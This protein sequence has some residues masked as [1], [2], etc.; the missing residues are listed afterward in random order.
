MQ[1]FTAPFI[2]RLKLNQFRT[3]FTGKPVW[4]G[5][6]LFA[7]MPMLPAHAQVRTIWQIGRFDESPVEF[8]GHA[9][10]SVAFRVGSS[11][12]LK[13]WPASQETGSTYRIL[14]PLGS[15]GGSY[16]L[17]IAALIDQPR[18][19]ALQIGIN[20]HSG[21]YFLHP[22]LSYSRS[23]FTYAFDPHESQST[24][25]IDIPAA[26]LKI[27]EN[28][29]SIT[30]VNDPPTNA[31]QKE[32]GGLSYDALELREEQAGR[33]KSVSELSASL[34]PTIFYRQSGT[35]LMEI[36]D[37][38]IRFPGSWKAGSADLEISGKHYIARL[39]GGEFGEERVSFEVPEWTGRVEAALRVAGGSSP[40]IKASLVAQRKWTIFVVPHT[41]LDVGFTD[42]QG[43]VA[44]TQ[45]RVLTQAASLIH[46]F[47]DF[48][49]S[50]DGS[51]NLEQF[52]DTRPESKQKELLDLIRS[53]KMAMPVQY[54]NLL[55]GYASLETLYQSLYESKRLSVR[56]GL[57]F[58]YANITDVP[59]Y[60]GSYPSVLAASGV[61]YWVAA[62]NNDRAPVF[63][64]DH[65]NE[66]SPFWW[67]GPDGNK[68]LFWYSRHYMQVQTLFGLPPQLEAVRES[69]PIYLQAY[70]SPAYK[71]DV[72]LIFGTQVENTDLFPSTATFAGGWN[73]GYAFPKL[74]YATFPDFFHY[75]EMHNAKDLPTVK[76]DGGG[77]WED[78][79]GSDAYFAAQ[80]RQNQNRVLS[81]EVL[82]SV[83]H[84][85]DPNL[86]P[87]SDAFASIWRN[88][89]LFAEHTWLS[90]NSVSQPDHE[91]SV[92]QLRVKDG[93]A[94]TAS[95]QIEDVMNR[96]LSQLADQ[97]HIPENTLVIF[98]S[99][100]WQRDAIV[101]TDLFEHPKLVDLAT[102]KEVPLQ[103]LYQKQ[104]FLHV[105][106]LAKDLPSVGYK[107]FSIS[108][109]ENGG[110][111]SARTNESVVENSF[112]RVTVD[113]DS[114]AVK[115]IF[116][117]QLRREIVDSA[118][119]YKFGQY[120]YVTG[121]DG[122]TQLVNPFPAL[123][124]GQLTVH[125]AS[126]GRL[127]GV[128]HLP[129]GESIRL[130]SSDVNTPSIETEILLFTDQ[131]KIEFRLRIHKDYTNAKE[132]VY[133][134]FPVAATNP[135]FN[136][137]TQQDWVNPARN[138]LKGGSLEWFN[139]QQWMAVSDANLAVGIVPV[140]TP[141]ANF[142]DINRGKWPGEFT[143]TT[144]TIFS[145]AMNNYWHTNYRAGQSG[146]FVFRYGV[147]SG[148][149]LG[150]GGLTRLG[151]EEMRPPEVNYVVSQD[152]AG[153]PAR[154]LAPTGTSFLTTDGEDIALV[155]WKKSQDGS[156]SILRLQE[157][158]GQP[159]ETTIVFPHTTLA[160]AQ[161]CSG[162][163]DNPRSL[164]IENGAMHLK[165]RPFEVLTVR[166]RTN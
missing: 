91:E 161:R 18:I 95:L 8:A 12:P 137:A 166:I 110:P 75:L 87:P 108:Y 19:P 154:P 49:F 89:I 105:R 22:K 69:L 165:F 132:G 146:D 81:A 115:S 39:S 23:D 20:G 72:A 149:R 113:P 17:K 43:K 14:F 44:E 58:E 55:T 101:E 82:S 103:I 106:F 26:F 66:K 145:Y 24:V 83:T 97:I 139:V 92:R 40:P 119:P 56:Y 11:D 65:W 62:S 150:G 112:Y 111:E 109:G 127:L 136:F 138:L 47:P 107:C 134:S 74:N 30:C 6:W 37:A 36:V 142:G 141:L 42:Y 84:S 117:K 100:N 32:I 135:E 73:K 93:R 79:I 34:E 151:F 21:R 85:V 28:A 153:N 126:H 76:G 46:E 128:E 29:L 120:L 13:D 15:I 133:V 4:K 90:Y 5:L 102:Q 122:D 160:S 33:K 162:V 130:S 68:V 25:E 57:P 159:A 156:G 140:D 148:P 125:P 78:G 88:I 54:C 80:D 48:R 67:E 71:P 99:L 59:T 158:A 50:M 3:A 114:G 124:P 164:M 144:G 31:G 116:D 163:E 118:S 143:A 63:Y 27:G 7:L 10:N 60:S 38:V 121:G 35:G 1:I 129:W 2:S 64:Y 152:K 86:N 45:A 53:G 147:T 123:P 41:H 155:T 96:S 70:S 104:N 61:K 52:L 16:V 77:Y 51:W 131:K 98:N 9:S 94:G 157:T